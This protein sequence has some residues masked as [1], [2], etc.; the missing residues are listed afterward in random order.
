MADE[1]LL[2]ELIGPDPAVGETGTEVVVPA[3]ARPDRTGVPVRPRPDSVK[4][5]P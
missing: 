1:S 5:T 4:T 3:S 2:E